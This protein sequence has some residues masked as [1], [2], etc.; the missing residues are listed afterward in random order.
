MDQTPINANTKRRRQLPAPVER[1]AMAFEEQ[2][3]WRGSDALR[4]AGGA[5]RSLL[6]AIAD[7]LRRW[8]V[9]PIQ[10]RVPLLDGPCRMPALGAVLVLAAAL[11][12][13]SVALDGSG[14]APGEPA[15]APVAASAAPT[16]KP[17]P[18]AAKPAAASPT[19]QGAAP[20]F[21]PAKK[22]AAQAG[23][24]KASS[25]AGEKGSDAGSGSGAKASSG[26][27]AGD[28][29]AAAATATLSSAPSAE[30]AGAESAPTEASGAEGPPAGPKALAVA[31]RFAAAF[32]LYETGGSEAKV[33]E[34]LTASATPELARSLL[35][36][37]PRLPKNVEV[38]KAKVVNVVAGPSSG[39]VYPVSVSLLR[40]GLTSELRLDMER[41][42]NRGW[43]VTNVLG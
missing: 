1:V 24:A 41:L 5:L 16:A 20:V 11:G 26:S 18:A 39:G 14:E 43:R 34:S 15:A 22:S 6:E 23:K 40:V 35:E 4:A 25:D 19:L 12:V 2:V 29:S 28:D 17:A 37:P 9:W 42:K 10:D 21:E 32:V 27:P 33:R 7:A 30:A 36:R 3:L 8:L 38:P 31:R 13:A